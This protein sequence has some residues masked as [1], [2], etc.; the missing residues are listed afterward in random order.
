MFSYRRYV[1]GV[2]IFSPYDF[3]HQFNVRLDEV[4]VYMN[5]TYNRRPQLCF[6]GKTRKALRYHVN[7]IWYSGFSGLD[8]P[9]DF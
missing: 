3:T 9:I 6:G 8:T 5:L 4:L 1:F 7:F 2:V